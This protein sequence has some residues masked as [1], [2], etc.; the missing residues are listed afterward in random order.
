MVWYWKGHI[1]RGGPERRW[2]NY[3]REHRATQQVIV[4]VVNAQLHQACSVASFSFWQLW[5]SFMVCTVYLKRKMYLTY[6]DSRLFNVWTWAELHEMLLQT[7]HPNTRFLPSKGSWAS[8]GANSSRC[9]L[10]EYIRYCFSAHK[11]FL[12]CL[13]MPRWSSTGDSW[14]KFECPPVERNYLGEWNAKAVR[15][16]N[17]WEKKICLL[18][19]IIYSKIDEMEARPGFANYLDKGKP[20][21]IT[22]TS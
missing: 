7:L 6:L 5:Q 14:S 20:D 18:T 11:I 13:G 15:S 16:L 17:D 2:V 8:W 19:T 4:N 3:T 21:R 10:H 9:N 22:S 12:D 1:I